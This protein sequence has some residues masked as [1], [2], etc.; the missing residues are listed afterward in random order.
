MGRP[1]AGIA[2]HT[3]NSAVMTVE[4]VVDQ[5]ANCFLEALGSP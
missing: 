3:R 5:G 2:R 1:M 4:T